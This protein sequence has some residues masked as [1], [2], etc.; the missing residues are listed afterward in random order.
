MVEPVQRDQA[1][2]ARTA[3]ALD[4]SKSPKLEEF[5]PSHGER[6]QPI[7]VESLAT[8]RFD[9]QPRRIAITAGRLDGEMGPDFLSRSGRHPVVGDGRRRVGCAALIRTDCHQTSEENDEAE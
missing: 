1:V 3:D 2:A 9:D 8:I 4:P 5:S 6:L 7:A